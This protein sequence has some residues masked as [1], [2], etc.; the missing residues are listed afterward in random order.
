[1][2]DAEALMAEARSGGSID[3]RALNL[4]MLRRIGDRAELVAAGI[5]SI[6][7]EAQRLWTASSAPDID[8]LVALRVRVWNFLEA[9]NGTSA[10]IVDAEDR[11]A[12]ALLC[13]LFAET[14][15]DDVWM[16]ADFFCEMMAGLPSMGTS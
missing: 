9:K 8:R 13:A 14:E 7:G 11:L 16:C 15:A 5:R 2:L 1:M 12:R 6:H 3:Y 10:T 4:A